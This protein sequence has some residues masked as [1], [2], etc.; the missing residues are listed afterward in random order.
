MRLMALGK[1]SGA[2]EVNHPHS[3]I[4]A[5]IKKKY[6]SRRVQVA[7]FVMYKQWGG[8]LYLHGK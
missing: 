8:L 2:N 7:K 3:T 4:T 6:M 1:S 5:E